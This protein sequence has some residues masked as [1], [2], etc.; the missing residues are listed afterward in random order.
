MVLKTNNNFVRISDNGTFLKCGLIMNSRL[1][2]VYQLDDYD[3]CEREYDRMM[4]ILPRTITDNLVLLDI[5][6]L[7]QE[8]LDKLISIGDY[9]GIIYKKFITHE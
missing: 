6:I 3:L 5:S 7:D 9:C 1:S 2:M 8:D 4:N